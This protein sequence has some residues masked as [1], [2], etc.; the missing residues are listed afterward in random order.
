MNLIQLFKVLVREPKAYFRRWRKG[1]SIQYH[2]P[3]LI[4][5]FPVTWLYDEIDAIQIGS[6]VL[7]GSFSEI[8][9][10]SKSPYSKIPGGLIIEDRAIIGSHANIRAAGGKVSIG[11]NCLIAQQVSLI[12]SNHGIS[13]ELP[14][15]DL[16]WEEERTGI[17]IHENVWIGAGVTVL[18]GCV[19]GKNSII[20]AGSVVTTSIPE[21]EIW[22]GVPARK[23]R[24]VEQQYQ[25]EMIE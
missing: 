11:R 13:H 18:P 21:N 5:N 23:L 19:I 7:I 2:N 22:V 3:G 16:P 12:A 14:Y 20:G 1:L 15:R 10:L 24:D 9:V 17:F 6:E 8:V 25:K 4:L